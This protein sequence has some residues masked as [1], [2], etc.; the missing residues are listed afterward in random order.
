MQTCSQLSL[1]SISTLTSVKHSQMLINTLPYFYPCVRASWV[2]KWVCFGC[3]H[4]I[5]FS[6]SHRDVRELY[7][8]PKTHNIFLPLVVC[9]GGD[10]LKDAQLQS[11]V[12][13][14]A[15]C[16]S[17]HLW[18][19]LLGCLSCVNCVV[20]L[21]QFWIQYWEPESWLQISWE[22]SQTSMDGCQ[23]NQATWLVFGHT[24][25]YTW[26]ASF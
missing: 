23:N 12:C 26:S 3:S 2:G 25:M 22:I 18:I 10:L 21:F 15:S 20:D 11:A 9:H 24:H 19:N 8:F 5:P 14:M 7:W 13:I 16:L 1:H 4:N 6:W 17:W